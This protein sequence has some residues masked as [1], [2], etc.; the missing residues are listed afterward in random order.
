MKYYLSLILFLLLIN[1][2]LAQDTSKTNQEISKHGLQFQ[3]RSLLE[4]TNFNGYTFSYRYRFNNNSGIRIGVF[5]SVNENDYNITQQLDSIVYN[6]PN[7]SHSYSF[8]LSFQYL[9]SLINYKDFSLIFGGGPFISY[10]KNEYSSEYL[11]TSYSHKYL[12]KDKTTG[13]GVDLILG[14]EYNLIEN[15]LISAEY[16]IT[17]SKENSNIDDSEDYIYTDTSQN[18][19]YRENGERH[20]VIVKGL[21]VNLGISVFF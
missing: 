9:H 16:G 20:S 15:V 12:N 14:A 18:R 11:S 5:T 19:I 17:L 13:F 8:K 1:F 10:S 2:T 21:G 7:Y 3:M 4:L 6:P